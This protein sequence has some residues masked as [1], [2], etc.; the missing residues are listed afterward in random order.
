MHQV[1]GDPHETAVKWKPASGEAVAEARPIPWEVWFITGLIVVG[2]ALSGAWM[3]VFCLVVGLLVGIPMFTRTG[4]GWW[5]AI[6]L[7]ILLAYLHLYQ[8]FTLPY[9]RRDDPV[10]TIRFVGAAMAGAQILLLIVTRARGAY[11]KE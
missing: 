5:I 1:K 3:N 2:A 8:A 9:E 4:W 7:S 11:E 10:K 6:L